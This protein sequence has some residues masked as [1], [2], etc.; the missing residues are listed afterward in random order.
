MTMIRFPL[1]ITQTR[2][3]HSPHKLLWI[4]LTIFALVAFWAVVIY[5]V[6]G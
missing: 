4:A 5:E 6:L 2:R 3:E 1:E